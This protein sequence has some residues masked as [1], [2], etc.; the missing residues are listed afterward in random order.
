MRKMKKIKDTNDNEKSS[1]IKEEEEANGIHSNQS[2]NEAT[3]ETDIKNEQNIV[4]IKRKL[5][6][7]IDTNLEPDD[8]KSVIDEEIIINVDSIKLEN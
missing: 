4:Q 8:F 7:S 2:N 1:M 3:S 6:G 5:N